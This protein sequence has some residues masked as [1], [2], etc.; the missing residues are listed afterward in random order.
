MMKNI[1]CFAVLLVTV[2]AQKV[3]IKTINMGLVL[4]NVSIVEVP[5]QDHVQEAHM[6][7]IKSKTFV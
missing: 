3:H 1:V 6:V 7:N 2:L 5:Q 4:I